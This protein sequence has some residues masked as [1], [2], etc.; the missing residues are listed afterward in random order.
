MV[1]LQVLKVKIL[2]RNIESNMNFTFRWRSLLLFLCN[3]LIFNSGV[4]K[5]TL[6][7]LHQRQQN[8]QGKNLF[9]L[10]GIERSLKKIWIGK[11]LIPS[12]CDWPPSH[13]HHRLQAQEGKCS[14]NIGENGLPAFIC[15]TPGKGYWRAQCWSKPWNML[16]NQ[17][18]SLRKSI[19]STQN[20][21]WIFM[22]LEPIWNTVKLYRAT[23]LLKC[24]WFLNFGRNFLSEKFLGGVW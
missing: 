23:K 13:L 4:K 18:V 19:A 5:L 2:N 20:K 9:W 17:N 21:F 14:W 8:S 1:L 7:F 12:L 11:V 22:H 24:C 6:T 16:P 3:I 10:R 15:G